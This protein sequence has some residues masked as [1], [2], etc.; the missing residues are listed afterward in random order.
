VK[1]PANA[2]GKDLGFL[3]LDALGTRIFG[4]EPPKTLPW[5]EQATQHEVSQRNSRSVGDP[6]HTIFTGGYRQPFNKKT[7]FGFQS[8][9]D[10]G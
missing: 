8:R 10:F 1:E 5:N 4:Y 3:A 6:A 9:Y 7:S 2:G